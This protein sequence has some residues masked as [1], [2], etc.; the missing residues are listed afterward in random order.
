MLKRPAH[1]Q[2]RQPWHVSRSHVHV[3][4]L[5]ESLK[6]QAERQRIGQTDQARVII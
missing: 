4:G 3:W 2:V 1:E 5:R 6:G